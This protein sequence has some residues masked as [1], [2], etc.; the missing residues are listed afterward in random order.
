MDRSDIAGLNA[1]R[2][3]M[4]HYGELDTPG[5]DN[6]SASYNQTVEPAIEEL[7]QIYASEGAADKVY[8]RVTPNSYHEMDNDLLK[9]FLSEDY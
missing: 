9:A 1:P 2:P 6:H 5:P 4:L 3:I 7:K 8:L